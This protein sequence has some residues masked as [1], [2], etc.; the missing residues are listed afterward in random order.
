[1]R[2]L[3]GVLGWAHGLVLRSV[4]RGA[5]EDDSPALADLVA[6]GLVDRDETGAP[7]ITPAGEAALAAGVPSRLER[8]GWTILSLTAVASV[9]ATVVGWVT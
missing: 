4:A 5:S 6:A 1:M 7:Q 3:A 2:K 8:I 9:G